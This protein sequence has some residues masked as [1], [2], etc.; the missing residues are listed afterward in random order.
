MAKQIFGDDYMS[1]E[2]MFTALEAN[3]KVYENSLT[4]T[5]EELAPDVKTV[6]QEKTIGLYQTL[7]GEDYKITTAVVD[8]KAVEDVD[9]YKTVL[10]SAKLET[11]GITAD[12]ISA[13]QQVEVQ[14]ALEDGTVITNQ[15]V[16][17]VKIGH[18]WYVDDLT[19]D[20]TGIYA[21][22]TNA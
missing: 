21:V 4:G 22:E 2:V 19:K 18:T 15:T 14:C 1:D 6:I 11:Y 10:D 20:T 3:V 16:Y 5:E 13:V 9:T 17:V 8:N 12:D 7:Y